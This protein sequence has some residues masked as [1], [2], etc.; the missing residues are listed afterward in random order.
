MSTEAELARVKV[1]I[2]STRPTEVSLDLRPSAVRAQ[3]IVH[4]L[5]AVD[6][7]M[8]RLSGIEFIAAT[9]DEPAVLR[10]KI[11]ARH[12]PGTYHGLIV[13]PETNT[14]AGSL[15]VRIGHG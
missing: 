1:E 9:D 3:L 15:S 11:P 4:A 13:D 10:I 6:A 8:P 7:E 12:P 5:R 14:P 2:A